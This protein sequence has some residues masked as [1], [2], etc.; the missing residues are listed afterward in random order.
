MASVLAQAPAARGNVARGDGDSAAV[1]GGCAGS[2]RQ[3]SMS[4]EA[5][6]CRGPRA[7]PALMFAYAAH[8]F[9]A[10]HGSFRPVPS[11]RPPRPTSPP[12][13]PP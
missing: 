5:W 8:L 11:A 3:A 2:P 4:M 1:G 10:C 6:R 9:D 13:Q 12:A 7:S